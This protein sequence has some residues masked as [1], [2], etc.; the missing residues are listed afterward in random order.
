MHSTW[1]HILVKVI[2]NGIILVANILS[3]MKGGG[4]NEI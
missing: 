3:S 2:T 1:K 4:K